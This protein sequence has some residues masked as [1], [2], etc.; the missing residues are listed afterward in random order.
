MVNSKN[1]D[2]FLEYFFKLI[3]KS[4]SKFANVQKFESE[5]NFSEFVL[6]LLTASKTIDVKIPKASLF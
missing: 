5:K 3:P 4:I 6:W 1:I 2:N